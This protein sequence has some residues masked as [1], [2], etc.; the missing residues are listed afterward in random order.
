MRPHQDTLCLPPEPLD[1]AI[2]DKRTLHRFKYDI[3]IYLICLT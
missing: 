3:K 2:I 1:E